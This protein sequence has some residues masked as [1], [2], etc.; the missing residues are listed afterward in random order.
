MATEDRRDCR[1]L[2][3]AGE[4]VRRAARER[5]AAARG[6]PPSL[7]QARRGGLGGRRGRRRGRR[8]AET[9]AAVAVAAA[10]AGHRAP[11]VGAATSRAR[12]DGGVRV[13]GRGQRRGDEADAERLATH[14]SCSRKTVER[15]CRGQLVRGRHPPGAE[16]FLS[17][18]DGDTGQH[19]ADEDSPT[20][21][22]LRETPPLMLSAWR[23]AELSA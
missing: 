7:L 8:A 21:T 23:R 9:R 4:S 12:A 22:Y 10:R 19:K 2:S 5:R 15:V 20:L 6:R 13:I 3:L 14:A 18:C 11:T 1:P 16:R 17:G